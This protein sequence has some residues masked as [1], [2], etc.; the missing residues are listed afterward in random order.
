MD[1][2]DGDKAPRVPSGK[3]ASAS[4]QSGQADA[5]IDHGFI[6]QLQPR[7]ASLSI[8]EQEIKAVAVAC[9]VI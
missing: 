7:P 3:A 1:T 9:K 2:D 8:Q 4:Q 6:Y 5:Q